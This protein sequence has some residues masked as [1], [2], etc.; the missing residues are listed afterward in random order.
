MARGAPARGRE[1]PSGFVSDGHAAL[2]RSE[3][4]LSGESGSARRPARSAMAAHASEPLIQGRAG[5]RV[6]LAGRHRGG[7]RGKA[8]TWESTLA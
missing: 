7:H 6:T 2:R 3:R 4:L 8:A 1:T 5:H